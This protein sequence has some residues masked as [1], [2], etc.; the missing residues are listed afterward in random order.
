MGVK[1]SQDRNDISAKSGP[2]EWVLRRGR[3]FRD[4][5]RSA[6]YLCIKI[7]WRIALQQQCMGAERTILRGCVIIS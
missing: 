4:I 1:W 2:F 6:Y 3:C 5:I 7:F